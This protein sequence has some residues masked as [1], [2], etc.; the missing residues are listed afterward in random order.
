ME[1]S[2]QPGVHMVL[3]VW[4][5]APGA[6]GRSSC[7]WLLVSILIILVQC[8]VLGTIVDE[9][10]YARCNTHVD[11][12]LGEFCAPSPSN[13]VRAVLLYVRQVIVPSLNP[14]NS[15]GRRFAPSAD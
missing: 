1:H 5:T 3:A 2:T 8:M 6:P 10:S 13:Q 4:A 7:G 12:K 15:V 14:S 9:S 11:C